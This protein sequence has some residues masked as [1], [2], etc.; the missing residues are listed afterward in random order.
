[1]DFDIDKA[2]IMMHGFKNGIYKGWSPFF[3][4]D[5]Y[6]NIKLSEELPIPNGTKY[7]LSTAGVNLAGFTNEILARDPEGKL[8][9]PD[10]INLLKLVKDHKTVNI[11]ESIISKKLLGII[12]RHNEYEY[13]N[14]SVKNLVVRNIIETSNHPN[15]QIA[16]YSPIDFGK[17]EI[18]KKNKENNFNLS[19]MDGISMDQQQQTNAVGKDV[20]GIA[21]NGIKD[22]FALVE[23]YSSYYKLPVKKTDS[24]YFERT[25]NLD[26]REV[27]VN[28]IAGLKLENSAAN[29][30]NGYLNNALGISDLFNPNTDPALV[31]SSLLSAATDNAKE[32]ILKTINAGKEFASMHLYLIMLGFDEGEVAGFMTSPENT[33]VLNTLKYN[34]FT[35]TSAR[36]NLDK[37]VNKEKGASEFKKIFNLSKE[38]SSLAA[39]LKI[40]QGMSS[41]AETIYRYFQ[42]IE[43]DFVSRELQF[44][45]DTNT[46]E[47]T[48]ITKDQNSLSDIDIMVDRVIAD[49]PYLVYDRAHVTDII[50]RATELDILNGGFS[51]A[52]FYEDGVYKTIALQYYNLIKGTFNLLDVVD[53]LAHFKGM[54]DATRIS[55]DH[56]KSLSKKFTFVSEIVPKILLDSGVTSSNHTYKIVGTNKINLSEDQLS[57]AFNVFD[58]LVISKWLGTRM[59][60]NTI[61]LNKVKAQMSGKGIFWNIKAFD[62]STR[63]FQPVLD[64]DIIINFKDDV[65]LANYKKF[66]EDNLVPYLKKTYPDNNFL[67]GLIVRKDTFNKEKSWLSTKVRMG[68]ALDPKNLDVLFNYQEG[69][70]TLDKDNIAVQLGDN[71]FRATD[72]FFLYNLIVNKD[73]SGTDRLTRLFKNYISDSNSLAADLYTYYS[74]IDSG[75]E[76]L[77]DENYMSNSALKK[78]ITFGVLNK[79]GSLTPDDRSPVIK[80][81]S[82]DF[83]M[84]TGIF[85]ESLDNKKLAIFEN[86]LKL[87]QN[88]NLLINFNCE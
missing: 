6:A 30:L 5:S 83:T 29:I 20:I 79:K 36:P 65:S 66:V 50:K 78:A 7:S 35:A 25:F 52:K 53:K 22:Y 21:A 86:L 13:N 31:L 87:I 27:K 23:Y 8:L 43:N 45:E 2:Y 40:N 63:K 68:K 10:I 19:L 77:L 18:I 60:T 81:I 71:N 26:G 32:L 74:K 62:K 75:E 11:P 14:S 1:M 37:A 47:N 44:I 67:K 9:L 58:D 82:P 57:K 51:F 48:K 88:K 16:S 54:I 15:N 38:L 39:I 85:A 46:K 64:E 42:T 61:N 4:Y 80:S 56:I 70:D 84:V 24:Q 76:D 73:R 17:Y 28:R 69:L 41:S 72:L 12:N 55:Y 34:V 3:N 49:K 33:L 59:G